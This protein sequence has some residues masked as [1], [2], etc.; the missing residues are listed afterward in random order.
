[1]PISLVVDQDCSIRDLL[2]KNAALTAE[3]AKLKAI[4]NDFGFLALAQEL[5]RQERDT[6]L[7]TFR[8][9]TRSK[10]FKE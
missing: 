8:S 1:M 6:A 7:P 5:E 3:L 2:K 10:M 4:V 9:S